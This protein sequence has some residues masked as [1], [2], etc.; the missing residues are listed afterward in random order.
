MIDPKITNTVIDANV[1]RYDGSA[2][3]AAVNRLISLWAEGEVTLVVPHSVMSE[4]EHPNTPPQA[5]QLANSQIF[6]IPVT[7]TPG[8]RE[9]RQL[10]RQILQGNAQTGKHWA[11]ADHVF[12][13]SK[14]GGYFITEDTR[15]NDKA[16][17][18]QPASELCIVRLAEFLAIYDRF[19]A[20]S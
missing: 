12:E 2:K 9:K 16:P 13:A 19:A 1:L 14:Y 15:I 11:D 10:M 7:L 8:E 17:K 5:K 3:D 20:A 6:S 4:L 18:L